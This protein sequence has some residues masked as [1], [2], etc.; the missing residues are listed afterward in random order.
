MRFP[1]RLAIVQGSLALFALGLVGK[2]GYEQ[3]YRHAYWAALGRRQ[4]YATSGLPAPR[5]DIEDAS[6]STLAE[7]REL[8]HLGVAPR[9]VADRAAL[10]AALR[11][12]GVDPGWVRTALDT[13]RRWVDIPGAFLP[14]DVAPA[15]AMRGVYAR[16]VMDRVYAS[17]AGLRP[18]VG[19]VGPARALDGVELALDS[20]LRGDTATV[21]VP[22]DRSGR[23]LEAPPGGR[24]PEP[25]NTVVLTLH[26]E[27]QDICDRALSDA[28]DSLHASGGD[29]V[30][31][32]PMTGEVLAMASRRVDPP[33]IANTAITEPY[34]PGSTVK[35]FVAARLL[36]LGRVRLDEQV[37]TFGGHLDIDGRHIDDADEHP[38]MMSLAEVIKHSSNVGIVLFA[39]RLTPREK[40]ELLRDAGFGT[41]TA[42]PL[43]AESPGILRDPTHWTKQTAASV[44]MGY[45]VAVT[46]LQVVTAY[47]AIAN[48]GL[49]LAPH[50]VQE[51][52]S[53]AGAVL[54]HDSTEVVRRIM[55]PQV[56]A[57]IRQ[58]LRGVVA[59]GTSTRADLATYDVAGKS[60]TARRTVRGRYA[61]GDYTASFVGLFP[62][63][64]PQFVIL[65]KLDHPRVGGYYGGV[66]AGGVTN[67][68]LRAALAAR[69]GALNLGELAA[70]A[71][72]PREDTSAAARAV[73]ADSA[74]RAVA[75][76]LADSVRA[77]ARPPA[78]V[79]IAVPPDSDPRTTASYV[80]TLP[81][82]ARIAPA[83][84]GTR[85]VPDVAGLPLRAAVRTL[86][87]AGFRVELTRGL[88]GTLPA[89][90]TPLTPG[91]VVRLGDSN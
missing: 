31:M 64:H 20:L 76:R 67:V 85:A 40:Y 59:S 3:L 69:D 80:V 87:A 83:V 10:A 15:A 68:V 81:A 90:G 34:E 55:S 79:A 11:A 50:I 51:I 2:A 28:V 57:T 5:G 74:R 41:P 9:E 33:G 78:R 43:P 36:M 54:Y 62:V 60:G 70:D 56:A 75:R 71:H 46:P 16:P 30:V 38:A 84:V 72:A 82:R 52:R 6:G 19:R 89:S 21:R 8:T 4:H 12:G 22:R 77:A 45:E 32:N 13:G 39:Q 23:V 14:S 27:L 17:S 47:S 49:L 53:P 91:R 65:V 86:H 25:G 58:M 37:N 63:E 66:L 18:I 88:T 7:S 42:V 1:D 24:E 48:G 29:I 26:R 73:R 61:A 35:P 44:A